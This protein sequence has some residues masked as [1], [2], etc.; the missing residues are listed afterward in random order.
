MI[1]ELKTWP[2]YF[3][4]VKSGKKSFEIRKDD[5]DFNK[6]DVLLLR[7]FKPCKNC[8]GTGRVETGCGDCD[9]CE[10]KEPHG[11]YT[12][13]KLKRK[14]VYILSGSEVFGLSEEYCV[15]A[16]KPIS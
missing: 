5:R 16:I 9:S 3:K 11:K 7:E 12:G 13:R 8:M 4:D 1:H 6:G 10:C 14:V 2:E 15:M